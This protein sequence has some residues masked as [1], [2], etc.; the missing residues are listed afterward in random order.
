[1]R[2][3][4]RIAAGLSRLVGVMIGLAFGG[5]AAAPAG[6]DHAT[7]L[8]AMAEPGCDGCHPADGSADRV[9]A[10]GPTAASAHRTCSDGACHSAAFGPRVQPDPLCAVCHAGVEAEVIWSNMDQMRGF[11]SRERAQSDVCVTFSHALHGDR[12]RMAPLEPVD[13]CG[14]CHDMAARGGSP[15]A[16]AGSQDEG[17]PTHA[18][19][20]G[21]HD[22]ARVGPDGPVRPD[23]GD[24]AGCHPAPGDGETC[25]PALRRARTVLRGFSHATHVGARHP[26][27]RRETRCGD[28]H[29]RV[30][31][32]ERVADIELIGQ[33][34]A[35]MN[36]ACRQCHDGRAA[37]HIDR[38]CAG[39]HPPGF[40]ER[41]APGARFTHARP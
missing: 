29:T 25:R 26:R 9:R 36:G 34:K 15:D 23:M 8:A 21:C 10:G 33:G 31:R 39:C 4:A 14:A 40:V 13:D 27:R 17:A 16:I 3:R 6:F 2:R 20:A 37:F 30:D 19:C 28:C 7:H 35:T 5:A 12:R 32:A 1:M 11:P 41:R 22:G 38:R 24:C 18:A